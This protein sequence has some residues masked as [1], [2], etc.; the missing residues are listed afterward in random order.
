MRPNVSEAL[1]TARILLVDRTRVPSLAEAV[2]IRLIEA[3]PHSPIESI[4]GSG[5]HVPSWLEVRRKIKETCPEMIVLLWSRQTQ[6]RFVMF[7]SKLVRLVWSGP[8]RCLDQDWL[9][10]VCSGHSLFPDAE[11]YMRWRNYEWSAADDEACRCSSLEESFVRPSWQSEALQQLRSVAPGEP[12][13]AEPPAVKPGKR[14]PSPQTTLIAQLLSRVEHGAETLK[15]FSLKRNKPDR[16]PILY[17]RLDYWN[18]GSIA[19]GSLGHTAHVIRG[20]CE[21]GADVRAAAGFKFPM[22]DAALCPMTIFKQPAA[23][24]LSLHYEHQFFAAN[25]SMSDLFMQL[26]MSLRPAFIYERIAIGNCVACKTA[27]GLGIPYV[28]EYNGSEIWVLRHWA[29]TPL[30]H[31]E[32]FLKL[33][34]AVLHAADMIVVVSE[35]LR[36]ELL[37]RGIDDAR[38]LVNSNAVDPH[39]FDTLRLTGERQ[40][41]RR[42][43]NYKPDDIVL[44]FIGTFGAW[45][46]IPT[47]ARALPGLI[48][49]DARIHV[50][51]IGDG[52]LRNEVDQV[53]RDGK[54]ENRV[55]VTG[56]IPQAEAPAYLAACDIYLSPH[57]IPAGDDRPFF[58]SPT[59]LFEYMSMG[60]PTI[61]SDLGQIAEVLSPALRIGELAS[62]DPQTD[63]LGVLVKPGDAGELVAAVEG[64][65]Q[66]PQLGERLANQARKRIMERH[67]WNVHVSRIIERL[68]RISG[69]AIFLK[70]TGRERDPAAGGSA[71]LVNGTVKS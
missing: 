23:D 38:I 9:E 25:A 13:I 20:F 61:A 31:E 48:R 68:E 2:L 22:V 17:S 19:G 64:L 57:Q 10:K 30:H 34:D 3:F 46:G 4:K 29:K 1:R 36:H 59:K 12:L 40:L 55:N 24:W 32:L 45:H 26:A 50:L 49:L 60:K 11:Q 53:I 67:T 16:Q 58:G 37:A 70:I 66:N 6:R 71:P 21:I 28:V 27:Q 14:P 35:P 43:F 41:I 8:L 54:L 47:L 39:E 51:L 52:N 33:E 62:A 65:I 42:K 7:D 18:A 15:A 63:A 44:G 56:I 5:T 69:Q